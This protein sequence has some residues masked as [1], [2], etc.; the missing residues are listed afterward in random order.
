MFLNNFTIKLPIQ[1]YDNCLY[2]FGENYPSVQ[3]QCFI[4]FY[5]KIL[6]TL[7]YNK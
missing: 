3:S 1:H 5:G 2:F 7:Y 4:K 6:G